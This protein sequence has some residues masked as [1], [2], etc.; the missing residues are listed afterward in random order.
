M[1]IN[2]SKTVLHV[3]HP[4]SRWLA[5]LLYSVDSKPVKGAMWHVVTNCQ[6]LTVVRG[7]FSRAA[8]IFASRLISSSLEYVCYINLHN[9]YNKI[10]SV[11][12]V[13]LYIQHPSEQVRKQY[14]SYN[15]TFYLNLTIVGNSSK[16]REH[17]G[18][19]FLC[20]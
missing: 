6:L 13:L 17:A 19:V 2:A 3:V 10:S 20:T 14:S 18:G 11:I 1:D 9:M 15:K 5:F 16:D 8:T 7:Y 4:S 12:V